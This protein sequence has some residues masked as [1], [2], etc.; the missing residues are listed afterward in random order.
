MQCVYIVHEKVVFSIVG[1]EP[2]ILSFFFFWLVLEF[3]KQ[4]N[5][6]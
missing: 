2:V 6:E 5:I 3:Y 4:L 1:Y